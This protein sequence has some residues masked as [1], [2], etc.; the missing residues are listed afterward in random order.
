MVSELQSAYY[1]QI[2][3]LLTDEYFQL[4]IMFLRCSWEYFYCRCIIYMLCLKG[5]IIKENVF[6]KAS[7]CKQGGKQL[8]FHWCIILT[9]DKY[10]Q[11][12][13]D[14]NN[15]LR[16][17]A[18][19]WWAANILYEDHSFPPLVL[20]FVRCWNYKC[21]FHRVFLLGADEDVLANDSTAC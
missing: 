14:E 10:R 19:V 3:S 21:S 12:S 4:S 20:V 17:R 11:P 1:Q 15:S 18:N 6:Q 2:L 13:W 7:F 8:F 5:I 9:G 16:C